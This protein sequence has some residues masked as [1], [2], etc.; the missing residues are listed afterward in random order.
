MYISMCI[1][2]IINYHNTGLATLLRSTKP[3]YFIFDAV[4]SYV[5]Y[6]G[7]YRTLNYEC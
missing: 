2:V 3:M 7:D 5:R 1:F 6:F 4:H